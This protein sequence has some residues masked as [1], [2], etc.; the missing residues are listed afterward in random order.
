[1]VPESRLE[2]NTRNEGVVQSCVSL[3]SQAKF[4]FVTGCLKN[5]SGK[6]SPRNLPWK[7]LLNLV[8]GFERLTSQKL[9]IF[10][11]ENK[12]H[13]GHFSK[14]KQLVEG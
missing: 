10:L 8:I 7:N 12:G 9:L 6:P 4:L 13:I 11:S 5:S 14:S 2:R 1:M 3:I